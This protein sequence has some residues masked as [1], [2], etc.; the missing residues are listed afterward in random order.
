MLTFTILYQFSGATGLPGSFA[1]AC[2]KIAAQIG[3]D[4]VVEE[5]DIVNE[6][7]EQHIIDDEV[8]IQI[9]KLIV[10]KYYHGG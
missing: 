1:E 3:I 7:K 9:K 10:G 6:A 2:D 5:F 8:W 4:V